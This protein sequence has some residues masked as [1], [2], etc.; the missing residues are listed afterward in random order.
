[1]VRS[2]S[3]RLSR[4]VCLP[5]FCGRK[6]SKQKRSEGSPELT[7]AGMRAVAPGSATTCW[8]AAMASRASRKPGSLMPGVPA[9]LMRATVSP[10]FSR[11]TMAAEVPCSL[12]LW[13]DC[14][15]FFMSKCFRRMPDVRVS[16]ANTRS[17]SLSMRTARSVISSI[18][19]TGVGTRY[20]VPIL[21]CVLED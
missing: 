15:W 5:F 21:L 13:C 12:N 1:M 4:R 18:L 7:S 17:A 19:P 16:S 8:P 6:P 3:R 2:S 11:S 14:R 20:S 9:S 10:A